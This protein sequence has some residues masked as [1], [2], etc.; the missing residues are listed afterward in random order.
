[1][2]G[3]VCMSRYHPQL[4][5]P[6]LTRHQSTMVDYFQTPTDKTSCSFKGFNNRDPEN[7]TFL[8]VYFH[9]LTAIRLIG[10]PRHLH[11]TYDCASDSFLLFLSNGFIQYKC[12]YR[13]NIG[14]II[15]LCFC[16]CFLSVLKF[17]YKSTHYIGSYKSQTNS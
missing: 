1:M 12:Q 6:L 10:K 11:C 9:I 5:Q 8:H 3:T 2:P 13:L 4:L 14:L 17:P 7:A 16:F 15:R